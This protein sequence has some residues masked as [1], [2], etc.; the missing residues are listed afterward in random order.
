MSNPNKKEDGDKINQT[1][2][3]INEGKMKLKFNSKFY[4]FKNELSM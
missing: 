2:K 1:V 3:L 4:S